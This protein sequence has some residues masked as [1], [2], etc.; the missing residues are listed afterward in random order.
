MAP[1]TIRIKFPQPRLGPPSFLLQMA[2]LER[3]KGGMDLA[4]LPSATEVW[5]TV[6]NVSLATVQLLFLIII[7]FGE[8]NVPG[9]SVIHPVKSDANTDPQ[10]EWPT[11]RR[12][13]AFPCLSACS[14]EP[15]S[16]LVWDEERD[17]FSSAAGEGLGG[18]TSVRDPNGSQHRCSFSGPHTIH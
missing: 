2:L 11:G 4:P 15:S 12:S 13:P 10:D 1:C 6:I 16:I 5:V 17:R 9:Q 14:G 7:L 3:G 8:I 18:D